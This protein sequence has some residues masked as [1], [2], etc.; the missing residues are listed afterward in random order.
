[1]PQL[2]GGSRYTGSYRQRPHS[3]LGDYST[4]A[5]DYARDYTA[6][7]DNGYYDHYDDYSGNYNSYN[8][9]YN[10]YGDSYRRRPY[11]SLG[12]YR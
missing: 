5:A 10:G 4:Y 8:G 9:D 1:M 11:S 7:Y 12:D 6:G 3:S 2:S